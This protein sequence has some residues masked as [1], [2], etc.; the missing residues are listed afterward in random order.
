M[1]V[2]IVGAGEIAKVHIKGVNKIEG[3]QVVGILDRYYT[4]G[5]M[6]A[7][8]VEEGHFILTNDY[9]V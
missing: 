8:M 3:A 6:L 2:C 7:E 9:F 4:R 5:E 1:R